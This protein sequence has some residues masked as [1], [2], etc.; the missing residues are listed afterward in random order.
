MPM[1]KH[2]LRWVKRHAL[3][4]GKSQTTRIA[5]EDSSNVLF[6]RTMAN[7]SFF[8]AY[9]IKT[10]PG[11]TAKLNFKIF[12]VLNVLSFGL[13]MA[14][15]LWN[16][17]TKAVPMATLHLR[18]KPYISHLDDVSLF[19]EISVLQLRDR[20]YVD[21]NR[22]SCSCFTMTWVRLSYIPLSFLVEYNQKCK[23]YCLN[24]KRCCSW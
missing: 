10:H 1:Y 5:E 18:A 19:I 4:L 9:M 16:N 22:I 8:V 17:G 14:N 23:R 21:G 7:I 15:L 13:K 12:V 6:S 20:I 24:I 2:L 11:R 3:R